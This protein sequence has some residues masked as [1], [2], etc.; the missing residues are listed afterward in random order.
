MILELSKNTVEI[1]YIG[2]V[3]NKCVV[4]FDIVLIINLVLAWGRNIVKLLARNL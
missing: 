3:V 2:L 4:S 1:E